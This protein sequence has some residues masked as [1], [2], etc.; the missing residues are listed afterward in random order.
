MIVTFEQHTQPLTSE[1]IKLSEII[2]ENM[3]RKYF[4]KE[5]AIKSPTIVNGMKASGFKMSGVRLRKIINHL[6]QSGSPIISTS[7]GYWYSTDRTELE[8]QIKSLDERALAIM[9]AANGLRKS[10]KTI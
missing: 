5:K 7:D 6:R 2:C 1:E 3:K 4:C 9:A 8:L 10:I